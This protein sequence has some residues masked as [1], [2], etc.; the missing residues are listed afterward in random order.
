VLVRVGKTAQYLGTLKASSLRVTYSD[1][2]MAQYNVKSLWGT[3][4][5]DSDI[6]RSNDLHEREY[7]KGTPMGIN[8]PSARP[9]NEIN[10]DLRK[11]VSL[12]Q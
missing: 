9:R 4:K 6:S 5:N 11:V 8:D 2:P 12:Q 1:T 10:L 7:H 3:P